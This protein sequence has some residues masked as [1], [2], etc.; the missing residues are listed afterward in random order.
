V[1]MLTSA[2]SFFIIDFLLV[3]KV[4][5]CPAF[6]FA[7]SCLSREAE[8]SLKPQGA[9]VFHVMPWFA[10]TMKRAM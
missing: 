1:D 10:F 2:M 3:W 7:Q 6:V 9:K 8:T 5:N 4:P